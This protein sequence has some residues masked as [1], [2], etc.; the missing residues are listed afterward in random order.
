MELIRGV[1]LNVIVALP[2]GWF[3]MLAVGIAHHDWWPA[4]PPIGFWWAVLL[5][6]LVRP[7]F[8]HPRRLDY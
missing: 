5:V 6:F 4:I 1:V 2:L 7:I 8:Y 3:F